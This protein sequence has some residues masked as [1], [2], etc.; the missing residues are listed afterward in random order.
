M[1]DSVRDVWE[2][3]FRGQEAIVVM[4]AGN[5]I[6]V[7]SYDQDGTEHSK[8]EIQRDGDAVRTRL[9][10]IREDRTWVVTVH[11]GPTAPGHCS[12]KMAPG[13]TAAGFVVV[14]RHGHGVRAESAGDEEDLPAEPAT[15]STWTWSDGTQATIHTGNCAE[16][17]AG[18]R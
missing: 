13:K 5:A 8:A 17:G 18:I 15:S 11:K 12:L 3:R 16:A 2:R 14:R 10:S 9:H 1:I 6:R 4:N 7:V